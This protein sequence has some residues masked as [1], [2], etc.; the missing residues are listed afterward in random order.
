M[1][2]K[3]Y[4][5]VRTFPPHT[6]GSEIELTDREAKYMLASGQIAEKGTEKAKPKSARKGK[7]D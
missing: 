5:V 6:E 3:T 7:A 2:K 4:I 1:I